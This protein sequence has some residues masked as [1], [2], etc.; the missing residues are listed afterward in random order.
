MTNNLSIATNDRVDLKK[1]VVKSVSEEEILA[2]Q[3]F[4]F[5]RHQIPSGTNWRPNSLP[6]VDSQMVTIPLNA[7]T[8]D[9]VH[10]NKSDD[11]YKSIYMKV[12]DDD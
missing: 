7:V 11:S 5:F 1:G 12:I 10:P 6:S 8:P 3:G 2:L 9:Q 4:M